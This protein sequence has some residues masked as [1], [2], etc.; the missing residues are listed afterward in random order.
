MKKM[1]SVGLVAL[2]TA[3]A[4]NRDAT[5][6][7]QDD[8]VLQSAKITFALPDGDDKDDNTAVDVTLTTRANGQWEITLASLR[9]F[10]LGT[11]WE[12]DGSHSYDYDLRVA[13]G[14]RKSTVINGGVKTRIGWNPDGDDRAFFSYTVTL[15]FSDGSEMNQAG[16]LIEMSEALRSHT[17]P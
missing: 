7:A 3:F 1:L 13:S 16:P 9:R 10:G 14:I 2:L 11:V 12:D 6:R 15:V 4:I 8:P 5:A 17:N